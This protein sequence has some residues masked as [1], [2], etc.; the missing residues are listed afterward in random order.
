MANKTILISVVFCCFYFGVFAQSTN[1]KTILETAERVFDWQQANPTGIDLWEWHYGTYY[2]GL[3]DLY[4]V[5]P[6]IKY[7]QAMFQMGNQYEWKLRPRPY[8]ADVFAITHMYI[9]LYSITRIPEMIDNT[10]YC[11]DAN[12]DRHPEEPGISVAT[13]R[14]WH[15]W[16]SWCDALFMAPPAYAKFSRVTGEK[17]YLDKMDELW[18]LTHNYLYDK[19][20]HL[21]YR[22]DN[23][24]SQKTPSGAKMF[25]SRGNGWV[26]GGLAKVLQE[27]PRDY[28]RRPFYEELFKQM[29]IKIISLQQKEGYWTCS[30]LDPTHFGGVETSGTAF[31]CYALAYGINSGLL[32]KA[33]YEQPVLKAWEVLVKNVNDEGRLGYVQQVGQSPEHVQPDD[34]EA[35]GSGAFFLAASEMFKLLKQ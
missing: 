34:S 16:W 9:D 4:K 5:D 18:S 24:F 35:Y 21:Y 23:Y 25:W 7:L 3:I 2:S 8:D 11:L 22:D 27:M 29:A 10:R 13:N 14:N 20:E 32:D 31:F 12:F 28:A 1:R 26:M 6:K 30:L 17:K 19:Q 33:I 15:N